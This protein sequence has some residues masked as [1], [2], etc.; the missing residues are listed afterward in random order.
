MFRLV[1]SIIF[2]IRPVRRL[3]SRMSDLKLRVLWPFRDF[4]LY[5]PSTRVVIKRYA[6]FYKDLR[7]YFKMPGAESFDIRWMIP[8]INDKYSSAGDVGQYF[9]Q[10]IWALKRIKETMVGSHVDVGSR[11]IFVGML[12]T[13]TRV[14]FVDVRPIQCNLANFET[15]IGDITSLP[16]PDN[17]V[18]SIS[19]LHVAEHTGLGRYGD[20]LDPKGTEKAAAELIRVLAPA[21]NLFFAIPVGKFERVYFNSHR[22]YSISSIIKMFSSLELVELSGIDGSNNYIENIDPGLFDEVTHPWGGVCLLWLK[23]AATVDQSE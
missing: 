23:K 4:W 5:P 15:K 2:P 17:S 21:G 20:K 11:M 7:S 1:K 13:L 9:Y 18:P 16:Y 12:S 6:Q 19:C 3:F 22:M 14:T 8:L 10:D